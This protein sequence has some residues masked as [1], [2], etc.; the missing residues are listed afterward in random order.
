MER[1][2]PIRSI[3]RNLF[4]CYRKTYSL[5]RQK[6]FPVIHF[7]FPVIHF[8]IPC[9]VRRELPP[10]SWKS[11]TRRAKSAE[12]GHPKKSEIPC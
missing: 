3:Q 7:E 10:E 5:F 8:E 2:G 11:A 6:I 4:P 1:N 12:T 9:S